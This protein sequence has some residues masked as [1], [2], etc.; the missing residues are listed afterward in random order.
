MAGGAYPTL[1]GFLSPIPEVV[2]G[3]SLILQFLITVLQKGED[4]RRYF[5]KGYFHRK[6]RSV[7]WH[8]NSPLQNPNKGAGIN[9]EINELVCLRSSP[10]LKFTSR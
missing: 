10:K 3:F 6:G 8:R 2:R 9:A 5:Q 1:K 7:K 4:L